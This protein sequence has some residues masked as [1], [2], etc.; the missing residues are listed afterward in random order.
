MISTAELNTGL[1]HAIFA[2]EKEDHFCDEAEMAYGRASR[3]EIVARLHGE[4]QADTY[5][6]GTGFDYYPHKNV[7][8]RRRMA[9]IPLEDLAVRYVFARRIARALPQRPDSVF[10]AVFANR[11]DRLLK[12]YFDE[13]M[14]FR[15]WQANQEPTHNA[16]VKTDISSFY[17][18]V[19]HS[20]L[21]NAAKLLGIQ[22]LEVF[23]LILRVPLISIDPRSSSATTRTSTSGLV[24]GCACDQVFANL[25]LKPVDDAMFEFPKLSFARY[26]DDMRIFAVSSETA[27]DALFVLQQLLLSRGL[28]LNSTKTSL[29]VTR[30][31]MKATRTPSFDMGLSGV[32]LEDGDEDVTVERRGDEILQALDPPL[33]ELPE[34]LSIEDELQP[35]DNLRAAGALLR[36][37]SRDTP[38]EVSHAFV[39]RAVELVRL[40]PGQ[41]K[42]TAWLL[43]FSITTLDVPA[44]TRD[45]ASTE[46]LKLLADATADN[47]LKARFLSMLCRH[48]RLARLGEHRDAF[49][50]AAA[51]SLAVP[52]YSLNVASLNFLKAAGWT[53]DDIRGMLQEHWREATDGPFKRWLSIIL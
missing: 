11:G 31:D 23:S 35:D 42:S 46:T 32:A 2:R 5:T 26:S 18:S 51:A 15:Q 34:G 40:D 12:P 19:S 49:I 29:H 25:Y 27:S 22:D 16:L 14:R 33:D 1:S 43:V 17:D 24:I 50:A 6:P 21:L 53:G 30:A 3:E 13:A 9:Y 39:D 52:S 41:S 37:A 48:K 28:N 8:C 7:L 36:R 4:L 47:Y 20:V 10:S 44:D 45:Y 38:T